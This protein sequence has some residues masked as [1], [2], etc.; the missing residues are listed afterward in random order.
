MVRCAGGVAVGYDLARAGELAA[1]R[2][3]RSLAGLVPD[4]AFVFVSGSDPDE[5]EDA[6]TQV[7][8]QK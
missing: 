1:G 7:K 8:Y 2:A 6:L 3:L 4:L 5:V